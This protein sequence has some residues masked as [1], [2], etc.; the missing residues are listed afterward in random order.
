MN[1]PSKNWGD[2]G[3][4]IANLR[5]NGLGSEGKK[6][7][8]QRGDSNWTLAPD[9]AATKSPMEAAQVAGVG[10][11]TAWAPRRHGVAAWSNAT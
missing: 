11:A 5:F 10:T 2:T 3:N 1:A 4:P 7:R 8:G 6:A 9:K